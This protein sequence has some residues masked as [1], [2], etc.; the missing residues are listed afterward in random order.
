MKG[1]LI[2]AT[3]INRCSIHVKYFE[4]RHQDYK[5]EQRNA[6]KIYTNVSNSLDSLEVSKTYLM[7]RWLFNVSGKSIAN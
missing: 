2:K 4:N 5:Q 3:V 1:C 6:K 7:D